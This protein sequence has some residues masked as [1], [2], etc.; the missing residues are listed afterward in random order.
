MERSNLIR[1][2]ARKPSTLRS[3][4]L[5]GISA[6]SLLLLAACSSSS[7]ATSASSS[8]ASSSSASS[9]AAAGSG[10]LVY[11]MIPDTVPSRYI[12]Q[13]GPDFQAALTKLDPGVTVKF[14]NANGDESTQEQQARAAIAA[15]AKALVVVAADP[16]LSGGLL[17][18]AAQ[19]K[20]P[21]I[22]YENV[23]IDGPMYAQ[24]EFSPLEAGQL[25]GKYFAQEVTSG[26]LGKYPVTLARLY[27]N[28]GDVYDTQMLK[29]QNQYLNPLISS[30]KVKVVC[31]AY[32][33]NWAE[34]SAVT[35]MQQCLSSTGNKVRA[36][37][38]FYD[39]I[40]QGAIVA[41]N[42]AHLTVGAKPS[43]ITV[44]GGQNPTTPGLQY[45][46]GGQQQDDVIKPFLY[47]AQT[48]ATLA[49]AALR[50]QKP[51]ANLITQQVNDGADNVP[52][53]FLG[54]DYITAG[55]DVG[56]LIN[57]YVVQ[58]GTETWAEICTSPITSSAICT[59]YQS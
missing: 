30:G 2:W 57:K 58:T 28:Q 32:T 15:G 42:N 10:G 50:G 59:T 4:V 25:Q 18:I 51:P 52:T 46:I 20:V 54:E 44:F 33:P 19:A 12:Q 11:F 1:A 37:L 53:A 39:G 26:A 3:R 22:G 35:E 45:L 14:V 16:P 13:D 17:Q 21:V 40:T 24:V 8:S 34:Q 5:I 23:P 56:A 55:P 31:Q 9:A 43:D 48:A 47:E 7:S 29:G 27:G 6:A 38:G 41:I 49:N 36:V